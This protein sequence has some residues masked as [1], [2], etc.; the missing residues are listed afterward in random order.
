METLTEQQIRTL[1]VKVP[2]TETREVNIAVPYYGKRTG[3]IVEYVKVTMDQTI[4]IQHFPRT[5]LWTMYPHIGLNDQ[6][7]ADLDISD[8]NEFAAA[9]NSY[10]DHIKP[11]VP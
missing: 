4:M 7:I 11:M 3:T 8:R 5:N 1:T 2:T 10:M 9:V 6:E